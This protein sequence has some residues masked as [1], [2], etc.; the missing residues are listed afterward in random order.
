MDA[1]YLSPSERLERELE[2]RLQRFQVLW[3]GFLVCTFAANILRD[4]P[5]LAVPLGLA[6]LVGI[7]IVFWAIVRVQMVREQR[8]RAAGNPPAWPARLP[9]DLFPGYAAAI[10]KTAAYGSQGAVF[11]TL[12]ATDH[13]LTWTSDR[14]T[15]KRLGQQLQLA[16]S[17]S[18]VVTVSRLRSP[19]FW[20]TGVG[21]MTI[22]DPDHE[23]MALLV[24]GAS[25]TRRT[26]GRR[27]LIAAS[28]DREP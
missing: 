13:G 2:K 10:G 6:I 7:Y 15:S 11:G 23:P 9:G 12:T 17:P 21:R 19:L 18:S 3:L 26:L 28:D 24:R 8:R 1:H 4:G 20:I 25:D 27:G 16:W 14:N 22:S 5:A